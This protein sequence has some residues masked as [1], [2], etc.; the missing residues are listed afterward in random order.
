MT[1]RKEEEAD[2]DA[3][4]RVTE[5]AFRDAQHSSYTE[6]F[7][8]NALRRCNQLTVSLVAVDLEAIVGHIAISPVIV[9]SNAVGW[10][11][12]GPLSVLPSY[13]RR[14][15]GSVLVTAALA[16]LRRLGGVG[17]VV[18][19]EPTY[20]RRFGFKAHPGLELP[21]VSAEFFAAVSFGTEVPVGSVRYHAAFRATA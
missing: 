1:V 15:I 2:A 21:G 10:Y 13:Q 17:C 14:G 3:I 4:S 7:I 5:A 18:L 20:Y 8:I 6:Q 19:G 12:L 9:S 11:G 16:E